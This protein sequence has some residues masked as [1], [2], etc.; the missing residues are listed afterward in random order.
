MVFSA[1][2][3]D[4]DFQTWFNDFKKEALEKGFSN[5]TLTKALNDISLDDR[6]MALDRKQPE[7]TMTYQGYM[8]AVVSPKRIKSA[9]KIYQDNKVLLHEISQR[10]GLSPEVL[11]SLWGIESNFSASQGHY[12][13]I[14]SLITLAYDGRRSSYFR[15]ELF[16][17]LEMLEKGVPLEKMTG[18]WA[19]AFGGCQFM[20]STFIRYAVHFDKQ[21]E[22]YPD[23]WNNKAD[24]LA[25]AAHYLSEIG[26]KKNHRWG[27][28]VKLNPKIVLEGQNLLI[29]HSLSEWKKMGV[30]SVNGHPLQGSMKQEAHL[31]QTKEGPSFLVYDNFNVI[32]EWNKSTLF[33]IAVLTLADKIK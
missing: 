29:N 6:V 14:R 3:E 33:A 20:P 23:I 22:T 11:V 30:L 26:W 2:S 17:S 1:Q 13:L 27:Q 9:K 8:K 4:V 21:E 15:G 28:R 5:E 16:H 31:V 25:S 10:Y 24:I 18:S 12:S 19:G 7:F 32:M